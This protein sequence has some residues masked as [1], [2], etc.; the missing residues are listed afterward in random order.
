MTKEP[1]GFVG[2]AEHA[3]HL[4]R[5]HALLGSGHEVRCEEPFVERHMAT[6]HDRS[7]ADGELVAAIAAEPITGLGLTAHDHAIGAAAM[8]TDRLSIG[9]ARAE[10]VLFGFGFV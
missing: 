3:L 10:D 6:L 7:S 2:H 5:A 9:P 4:L 8:R 1:C